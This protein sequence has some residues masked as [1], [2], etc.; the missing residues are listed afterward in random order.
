MEIN[1]IVEL[2]FS[3][4]DVVKSFLKATGYHI[5]ESNHSQTIQTPLMKVGFDWEALDFYTRATQLGF[6]LHG[7][8]GFS[9]YPN[10]DKLINLE[11]KRS[12]KLK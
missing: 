10:L 7:G 4:W 12:K 11:Y 8:R 2:V 6:I 9:E 3:D 1:R 5:I